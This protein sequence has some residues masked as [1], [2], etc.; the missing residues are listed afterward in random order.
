MD[1]HIIEKRESLLDVVLD[2]ASKR[3]TVMT[4]RVVIVSTF[5]RKI[6]SN[7]AHDVRDAHEDFLNNSREP[8][9]DQITGI[10]IIYPTCCI[11]MLEASTKTILAF[12][13]LQQQ[14][15]ADIFNQSSVISCTEDVPHLAF[16]FWEASFVNTPGPSGEVDACDEESLVNVASEVNLNL[17]KMGQHFSTMTSEGCSAALQSLKT[18]WPDLPKPETIHSMILAT[19]VPSVGDFLE[20]FNTPVNLDLES[21]KI[22]PVESLS[23]LILNAGPP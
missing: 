8:E 15:G 9:D 5:V 21:E 2:R 10:L 23:N 6:T 4:T 13:T 7:E 11:H 17:L 12:M 14:E 19:D 1:H 18:T 3:K 16:D 20:I 22:W